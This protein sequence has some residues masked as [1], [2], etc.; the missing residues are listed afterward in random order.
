MTP[1]EMSPKHSLAQRL[2]PVHVVDSL[3]ERVNPGAAGLLGNFVRSNKFL[4]CF[5]D[6][7]Q[8]TA[9]LAQLSADQLKSYSELA[10]H[11]AFTEL[12]KGLDPLF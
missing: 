9:F 7:L 4:A 12:Q 11:L 6:L 5:L 10:S 2:L 1:A 3:L 8:A